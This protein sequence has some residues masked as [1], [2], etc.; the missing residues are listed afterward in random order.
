M[1][2]WRAAIDGEECNTPSEVIIIPF[3]SI[4]AVKVNLEFR[5]FQTRSSPAEINP[6]FNKSVR[7]NIES[8]SLLSDRM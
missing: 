3:G 6:A 1:L 7:R 5:R 4:F 8:M 2:T